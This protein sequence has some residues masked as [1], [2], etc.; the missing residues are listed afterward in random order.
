MNT[1]RLKRTTEKG[2][3]IDVVLTSN[4]PDEFVQNNRVGD[5]VEHQ[6]QSEAD[7]NSLVSLPNCVSSDGENDYHNVRFEFGGAID[8]FSCRTYFRPS[9]IQRERALRNPRDESQMIR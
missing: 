6:E 4:P 3:R 9:L 7:S 1:R 8:G 5:L 2:Q